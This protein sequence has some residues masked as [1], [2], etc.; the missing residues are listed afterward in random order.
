MKP[1][2][3]C[4]SDYYGVNLYRQRDASDVTVSGYIETL[5][6]DVV[7]LVVAVVTGHR[8]GDE[9]A[10]VVTSEPLRVGWVRGWVLLRD[11]TR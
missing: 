8:Q 4:T 3:L 2:D 6:F 1:G 10:Y 7:M 5:P 9:F 11:V